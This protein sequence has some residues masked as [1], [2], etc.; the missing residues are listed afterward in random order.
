MRRGLLAL[1]PAFAVWW[2]LTPAYNVFLVHGGET[3]M[4][5][6]ERPAMTQIYLET[7]HRAALTRGDLLHRT[8][9]IYG[10]RMTDIHFHVILIL[11]LFL[12]VPDLPWRERLPHLGWALLLA[13]CFHLLLIVFI[14]KSVYATQ[15]GAWSLER[16]GAFARNFYGLGRHLLDLPVKLGLPFALWAYFYL[17][18]LPRADARRP[19]TRAR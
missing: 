2:V 18:R 15:L 9:F 5:L 12:A 16:Y 7:T 1:P 11:A 3:L 6:T 19:P 13:V 4:R 10:F 17:D 8:G 14:A